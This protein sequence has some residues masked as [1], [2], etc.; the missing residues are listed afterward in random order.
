QA[1]RDRAFVRLEYQLESQ[2]AAALSL[3]LDEV[4]QFV[5]PFFAAC[6][7]EL[8][9]VGQLGNRLNSAHDVVVYLISA[10][11]KLLLGEC[12]GNGQIL[13]GHNA[14]P[15]NFTATYKPLL[16]GQSSTRAVQNLILRTDSRFGRSYL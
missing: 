4:Y 9:T 7:V 12:A 15:S 11:L 10:P 3:L 13:R 2:E 6:E 8:I 14:T 16:S 5:S 1:H